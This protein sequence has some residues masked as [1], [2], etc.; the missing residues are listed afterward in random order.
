MKTKK[1][2]PLT[3]I[4]ESLT[5]IITRLNKTPNTKL[6]EVWDTWDDITK[7]PVSDNS[8]PAAIRGDALYVN[9]SSSPWLQ[10]LQFLKD[11]LLEK[12]NNNS[13]NVTFKKIIFKIG[14]V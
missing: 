1:N 13:K 14:R 11:D 2:S 4:S 7:G 8:K 12:L 9:V 3:H 10:Q 5:K 6:K